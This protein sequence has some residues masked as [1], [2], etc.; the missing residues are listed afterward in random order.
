M[1]IA[2]IIP[3]RFQSTRFEGKPLVK[4]C[5]V[6]MIERVYRQ[7]EKCG[8]FPAGHIIVATDDRRIA[9]EVVSFGGT[10]RMT[11]PHHQSGSERLWEVLQ[12]GD[13]EA[14]INIQ[15]D[16]PIISPRLIASLYDELK[17]GTSPVV[18]PAY[19]N[20]EY[21]DFLSRHVTKV[22]L[23]KNS[24]ALYF[25]RSPIPFTEEKDFKGFHHHLGMY[26]YFCQSLE[27]F[28]K[29]ERS[30]LEA[31]EK[32]EQL[33]FLENGIPIKVIS[34]PEKSVGV[35]VPEDLVEVEGILNSNK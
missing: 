17:S 28:V 11:S 26:G 2:A 5:G 33:R 16:E 34:S 7:V 3:A 8:K 9:D 1:K 12:N 21:K 15:G 27:M 29:A 35:D 25:S 22:V 6:T 10:A 24:R 23:D 19:Y 18:T 14:A 20:T 32:L 31:L 13:F 30:T 4:I